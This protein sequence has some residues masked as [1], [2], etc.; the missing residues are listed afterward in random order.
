MSSEQLGHQ[1]PPTTM[2]AGALWLLAVVLV[3]GSSTSAGEYMGLCEYCADPLP[4]HS[5]KEGPG[6]RV[7]AQAPGLSVGLRQGPSP[8]P[9]THTY[10]SLITAIYQTHTFSLNSPTD[11]VLLSHFTDRETEARKVNN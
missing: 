3:L 6:G 7:G 8:P 11:W 4:S 2:E 9:H 1:S 10:T 5:R